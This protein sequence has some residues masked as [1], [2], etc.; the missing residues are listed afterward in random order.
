MITAP[1]L[2][3]GAILPFAAEFNGLVGTGPPPILLQNSIDQQSGADDRGQ[4]HQQA[5]FA[6]GFHTGH[7]EFHQPNGQGRKGQHKS[8]NGAVVMQPYP[9]WC[10][11]QIPAGARTEKE[12]G[13]T[14]ISVQ[15]LQQHRCQQTEQPSA[16][17]PGTSRAYGG[18][19]GQAKRWYR[20]YRLGGSSMERAWMHRR[21]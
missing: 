16:R 19:G 18:T 17:R 2:L 5:G 21:F 8:G 3:D 20:A 7:M 11:G 15:R 13:Q 9:Y 10:F 12:R 6:P 14:P 1:W 4:H